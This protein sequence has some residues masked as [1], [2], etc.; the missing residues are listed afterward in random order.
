MFYSKKIL[1][2]VL[3]KFMKE[4]KIKNVITCNDNIVFFHNVEFVNSEI[5][6]Y[7]YIARNSTVHNTII[8]KFCSIGP[9]VVIG[10]GDHPTHFLSTSPTFYSSFTDFDLKP[11]KNLF[12]GH[13]SVYIGNDVWI[14]S[15]VF[16]KNGVKIGD[17]AIIGAGCVV[18]RD[19]EPYSIVVGVPG[20]LKS[21]RFSDEI[22]DKLL[23]LKWW[24][25]PIELIK[26]NHSIL[27]SENI[28]KNI[29]ELF[30]INNLNNF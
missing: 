7:S 30:K 17:G 20:N 29:D 26:E 23:K 21:K 28:I 1:K 2:N 9:N 6:E 4:K 22:I 5:G 3:S 14:G 12:F 11:N 16:I 10:Y 18:I 15:N 13:S 19:V 25:W 24:D 27:S 8:G